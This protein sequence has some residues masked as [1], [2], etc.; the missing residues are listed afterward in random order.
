MKKYKVKPDD[1]IG[2][3]HGFPLIVVQMMVNHQLKQGNKADV[4]VFQMH[5]TANGHEGGFHWSITNEGHSYWYNAVHRN[6]FDIP[7]YPIV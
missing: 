3:I 2:S 5:I 4:K 6:K 1:L 7:K